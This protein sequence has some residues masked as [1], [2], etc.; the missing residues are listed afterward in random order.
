MGSKLVNKMSDDWGNKFFDSL[1]QR[2]TIMLTWTST[3][4]VVGHY[5]FIK[6]GEW[7]KHVKE[8]HYG[9]W[10]SAQDPSVLYGGNEPVHKMQGHWFGPIP[11][12]K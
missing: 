3:P 8:V 1:R 10:R 11:D 5:V 6:L 12:F 7:P 2:E 4:T 9:N